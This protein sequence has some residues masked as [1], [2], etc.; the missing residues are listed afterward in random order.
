MLDVHRTEEE[1]KAK[2]VRFPQPCGLT[3]ANIRRKLSRLFVAVRPATHLNPSHVHH[4]LSR[5]LQDE[6]DILKAKI[7][8]LEREN[9]QHAETNEK[10]EQKVRNGAGVPVVCSV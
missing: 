7:A 1:L 4:I 8:K 10:L 9:K 3:N 5:F 6:L 2:A